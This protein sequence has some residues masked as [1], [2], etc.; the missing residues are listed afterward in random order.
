M[1]TTA[2]EWQRVIETTVTIDEETNQYIKQFDEQFFTYCEQELSK[3]NTFFAEKLAEAIR[4]FGDLKS[5]LNSS[6][7]LRQN[8]KDKMKQKDDK[9]FGLFDRQVINENNDRLNIDRKVSRKLHDLKLAF[10]EFYLALVL[11]Q[12]YQNLNFTGFRKILKK[13]DK[14]LNTNSGLEWRQTNVEVSHFYTN[15]EVNQLVLETE[16]L[17]TTHLE[18]GDRQKAMKRLR[19]PPLNAHQSVWTTFRVGIFL[20]AFVVLLFNVMIVS[21]LVELGHEWPVVVRLFR[22]PL[23]IIVFLFMIG[24]NVYGWRTS[25]VNH[26]LIFELDPRDHLSEQHFFE[27]AAIFAVLWSLSVLSYLFSPNI[28]SINANLFPLLL[29]RVI[30]APFVKVEFADFWLADQLNSIVPVLQDFEFLICYYFNFYTITSHKE[31][32]TSSDCCITSTTTDLLIRTF[33]ACLPAWFRFAQ[34]L[35]RYK[36]DRRGL[37]PHVVNAGKYSTTFFVVIFSTLTVMTT[38]DYDHSF[39]NPYFNLWIISMIVNACYTYVWDVKMDWG[40]FDPNSPSKEYPFLREEIVYSSPNYYYFAIIED[41]ILRFGWTLSVSLK[42]V[43]VIHS[44]IVTSILAP[45]ELFRSNSSMSA[46]I[47]GNNCDVNLLMDDTDTCEL[48]R[49]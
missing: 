2:D 35:R 44:E 13:H 31:F 5:E 14:L 32:E 12:N 8:G 36:D 30:R 17:F 4:R 21:M 41:L 49:L 29:I 48:N 24:I 40:L 1:L 3:I 10:S 27:I 7:H 23:M 26:V 47:R 34:C 38:N 25:G 33:V 9:L 11:L 39:S 45:L 15:N 18:S 6:Q 19:V 46:S 43:G 16:N 37:F 28:L 42:E 22:G 20:G